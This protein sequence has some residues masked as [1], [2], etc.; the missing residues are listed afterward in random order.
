MGSPVTLLKARVP[1][2]GGFDVAQLQIKTKN[3]QVN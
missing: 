1:R 2:T 3:N